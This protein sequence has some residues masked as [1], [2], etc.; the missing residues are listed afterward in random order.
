MG[1][2]LPLFITMTHFL[3]VNANDAGPNH[4]LMLA[5]IGAVLAGAIFG[6]HCSPISDTTILSSAATGCDHLQHVATQ[7]P[8][9]LVVAGIAL[10]LGY[11]P[12]GF[13]F[14]PIIMLPLGVLAVYAVVQFVGKPVDEIARSTATDRENPVEDENSPPDSEDSREENSPQ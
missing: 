5:S 6:D 10:L 7:F 14:S 2:L 4:H 11:V 9:A 8:Y 1:L 12:V 13:G 3:L